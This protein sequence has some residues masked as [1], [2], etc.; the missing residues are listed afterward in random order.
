MLMFGL[1][2]EYICTYIFEH[3]IYSESLILFLNFVLQFT[4]AFG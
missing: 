1:W 2:V 4:D 3:F